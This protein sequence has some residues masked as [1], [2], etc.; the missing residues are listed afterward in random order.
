MA[1][2]LPLA[3]LHSHMLIVM[4]IIEISRAWKTP[5]RGL[6]L[7][8]MLLM[9][10]IIAQVIVFAIKRVDDQTFLLQ[11]VVIFSLVPDYT[12]FGSQHYNQV[13][14]VAMTIAYVPFLLHISFDQFLS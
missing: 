2:Y 4:S 10:T 3:N 13:Q 1:L 9:A 7:A 8:V 6:L 14:Q 12:M 5:P 11:N